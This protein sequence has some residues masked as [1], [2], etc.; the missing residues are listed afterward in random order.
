M[1]Y[2]ESQDN[3][4]LTQ[5]VQNSKLLLSIINYNSQLSEKKVGDL[6]DHTTDNRVKGTK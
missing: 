4:N 3:R 5:R 1:I 6:H 2:E